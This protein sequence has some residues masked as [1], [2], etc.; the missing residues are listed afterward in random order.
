MGEQIKEAI[1]TYNKGTSS[2]IKIRQ[3]KYLNN[4]VEADRRFVKWRTHN[5]L[6]FKCLESASRALTG[7][8]IVRMIKKEQVIVPS[9]TAYS[10]F[11]SLVH[12]LLHNNSILA[13]FQ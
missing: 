13:L 11:C 9:V 8:E 5:M 10:T 12:K 7:I 4:R 1:S 2:N 3:C 6:G